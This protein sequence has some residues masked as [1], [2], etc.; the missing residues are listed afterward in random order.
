MANPN[1]NTGQPILEALEVLRPGHNDL[2]DPDLAH[3]ILAQAAQAIDEDPRLAARLAR[4]A[5]TDEQLASVFPEVPVPAGLEERL[6]ARLAT[7]EPLTGDA[8]QPTLSSRFVKSR[9]LWASVA[10]VAASIA[11]AIYLWPQVVQPDPMSP[12]SLLSQA[13]AH[14]NSE[15]GV[16]GTSVAEQSPP[17][18]FA[19][20]SDVRHVT[21][22]RWRKIEDFVGSPAVAY[23][24]TGG[25]GEVATLYV[26]RRKLAKLEM[27]TLPT[28]QP[29]LATGGV[30]ATCWQDVDMLYV[31]VVEGGQEQYDAFVRQPGST[32]AIRLP[33]RIPAARLAQPA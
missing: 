4:I 24:L 26:A 1:S 20:S 19:A 11:V 12:S 10:A 21:T 25:P 6:L 3:P 16:S 27:V 22:A 15:V 32:I 13:I 14:F 18:E 2:A 31:L 17:A 7:S 33:A 29:W 9:L 8:E 30:S 23:D 28:P 5:H